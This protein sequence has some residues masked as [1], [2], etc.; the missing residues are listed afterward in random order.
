VRT[1]GIRYREGAILL[2][3]HLEIV[4][5]SIVLWCG[6]SWLTAAELAIQHGYQLCVHAI[7]DRANRETLDIYEQAFRPF[8]P[9]IACVSDKH[10]QNLIYKPFTSFPRLTL[11]PDLIS[12]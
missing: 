11:L 1:K 10:V 5:D 8:S 6:R 4:S 3:R 9:P 2:R 12:Y 7:G